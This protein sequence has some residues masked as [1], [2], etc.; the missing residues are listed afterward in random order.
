MMAATATSTF[1]TSI[2]STILMDF[3]AEHA[4]K[5]MARIRERVLHGSVSVTKL[6]KPPKPTHETGQTSLF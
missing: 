4:E 3:S 6:R 2:I 5:A 1:T